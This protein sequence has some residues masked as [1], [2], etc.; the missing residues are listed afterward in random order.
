MV[1]DWLITKIE[2]VKKNIC[3]D[4]VKYSGVTGWNNCKSRNYIF[5]KHSEIISEQFWRLNDNLILEI[6]KYYRYSVII[7]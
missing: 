5:L 6:K 3:K 1:C 4:G 2:Q 7:H